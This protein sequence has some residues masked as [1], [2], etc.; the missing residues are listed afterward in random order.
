MHGTR[1]HPLL[2]ALH[3]LVAGLVAWTVIVVLSMDLFTSRATLLALHRSIG[4]TILVLVL[5]RL[6]LRLALPSPA[7][8]DLPFAL[9]LASRASHG[10]L[11]ALLLALP[12]LG[13]LGTNAQ[14]HPLVLF[15]AVRLPTLLGKDPYLASAIMDVHENG[16]WVLLA[17]VGLHA[18]AALWHHYGRRDGALA[19]MLPVAAARLPV[20]DAHLRS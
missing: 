17:L 18:V 6:A 11:Y 16:A 20:G 8:D 15:D 19:R 7:K 1:Y 14:G 12:I 3:W 2:I 4:I 9:L 5:V 13:W 10:I